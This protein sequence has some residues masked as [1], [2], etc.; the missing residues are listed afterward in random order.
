MAWPALSA[1][2]RALLLGLVAA[3]PAG[4]PQVVASFSI[5]GDLVRQLAGP[6]VALRTLLGPEAD[7]HDYAP[8]PSDAALLREATLIVRN[9]LGL[10]PWLDRLLRAA[11]PR[12]RVLTLGE[13][14]TPLA[15]PRGPDPHAW[16]DPRLAMT[17][18]RALAEALAVPPDAYLAR[19]E[20]LDA[21]LAAV[22]AALPAERRV[23][24]VGH[25]AFGYLAARYGLEVLTPAGRSAA[26]VAAFIRAI[27]ERRLHG[28]YF[29][30]ADD[31]ALMRRVAAEAGVP[32]LGRLYAETLSTV[33][34]V[35]P[36]YELLM[37][38]NARLLAG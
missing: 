32:L 34:G 16:L 2:R 6:G 4:P 33:E 14:I 25:A 19:L 36:T 24:A 15:L 11:P 3:A 7:P 27:R 18:V 23:F 20:R 8:R 31:A 37:R 26:A 12:G 30:G 9:G 28:V 29:S 5:L 38:H 10:E 22:Y 17:Y 13:T 21:E 1:P 35:A